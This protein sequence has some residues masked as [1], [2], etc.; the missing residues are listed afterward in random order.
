MTAICIIKI[1]GQAENMAINGRFEINN[2][3]KKYTDI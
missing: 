3:L 1:D 2:S